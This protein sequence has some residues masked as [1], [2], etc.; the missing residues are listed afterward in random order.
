MADLKK[1]NYQSPDE[2]QGTLNSFQPL[3]QGMEDF[4][5]Q[6]QAPDHE[7]AALREHLMKVVQSQAPTTDP[8]LARIQKMPPG[9]VG[10]Y[11]WQDNKTPELNPKLRERARW[12]QSALA[13]YEDVSQGFN[14]KPHVS[15]K[16]K[17]VFK[18][19]DVYMNINRMAFPDKR[20]KESLDAFKKAIGNDTYALIQT[21][22]DNPPNRE[23]P[24]RGQ[25]TQRDWKKA[26][27][28]I[29]RDLGNEAADTLENYLGQIE[30]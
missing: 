8:A 22:I 1:V 19:G 16:F 18:P 3:P 24:V 15:D 9:S 6:H 11:D 25:M 7:K 13:A 17:D 30:D 4:L 12:K 2:V 20:D 14:G 27:G 26:V 23:S 5:A 28:E 21:M 29:R 10:P